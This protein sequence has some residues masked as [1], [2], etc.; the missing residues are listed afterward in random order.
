MSEEY[1]LTL[2][3]VNLEPFKKWPLTTTDI[4]ELLSA[5]QEFP[6]IDDT[7]IDFINRRSRLT[8]L[9]GLIGA[10]A[11]VSNGDGTVTVELTN[12]HINNPSPYDLDAYRTIEED[13]A[14]ANEV[15]HIGLK[16]NNALYSKL[17]SFC[18]WNL[19]SSLSDAEIAKLPLL[20]DTFDR[21]VIFCPSKNFSAWIHQLIGDEYYL[22]EVSYDE[23]NTNNIC[24]AV[25]TKND[26]LSW[27]ESSD[28]WD[29]PH[30]YGT[31]LN[32]LIYNA[33]TLEVIHIQS[34]R[35]K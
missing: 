29:N 4:P 23:H 7:F 15:I 33:A 11:P 34:Y 9:I 26:S 6:A 35:T 24:I 31:H 21:D 28:H 14:R 2:P 3:E 10:R 12:T 20:T 17:F 16:Y 27:V 1:I 32:F 8:L 13:A 5:I 30:R 19:K 22:H 25:G 18:E